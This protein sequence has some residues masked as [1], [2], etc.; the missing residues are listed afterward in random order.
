MGRIVG[1]LCLKQMGLFNFWVYLREFERVAG[2][3]G[4][5]QGV[6][7]VLVCGMQVEK[8]GKRKYIEGSKEQQD[9]GFGDVIEIGQVWE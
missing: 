9:R 1:I 2:A 4:M 8:L 5:C 7:Y 6:V 3:E